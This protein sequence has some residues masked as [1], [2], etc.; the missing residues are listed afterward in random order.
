MRQLID[1]IGEIDSGKVCATFQG[2]LLLFILHF[3]ASLAVNI[4]H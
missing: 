2:Q 4:G 1:F 3:I